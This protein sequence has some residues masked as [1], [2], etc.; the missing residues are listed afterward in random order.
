[1]FS[2]ESSEGKKV[3]SKD[4]HVVKLYEEFRMDFMS[5][6]LQAIHHAA[7]MLNHGC[8]TCFFKF[9]FSSIMNTGLKMGP[10]G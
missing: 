2:S 6:F 9:L 8:V 10:M 7:N 3:H 5:Y 4:D 1:M